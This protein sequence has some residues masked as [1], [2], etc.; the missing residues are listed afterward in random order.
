MDSAGVNVMVGWEPRPRDITAP[1]DTADIKWAKLQV[2]LQLIPTDPPA[3]TA[4]TVCL[5][6]DARRGQGIVP[7]SIIRRVRLYYPA[8]IN[9]DSCPRTYASMIQDADSAGD[10]PRKRPKGYV[11]PTWITVLAVEPWTRDIY[12]V[13]A[14]AGAGTAA[15]RYYC[16]STRD[17]RGRWT[18][19]CQAQERVAH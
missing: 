17:E 5:R 9:A 15:T 14:E 16:E 4:G 7:P 6:W 13:R 1:Y 8:V 18:A 12:V 2:L 11:D 10:S 3:D 19:N